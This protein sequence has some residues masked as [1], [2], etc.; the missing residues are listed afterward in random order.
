MAKADE[1]REKLDGLR[2]GPMG[3]YD[4]FFADLNE[5]LSDEQRAT[6]AKFRE[7][8]QRRG[9][10]QE[11]GVRQMMQAVRR[12]DL[13]PE[14]REKVNELMREANAPRDREER[15]SPEA[16]REFRQ[17]LFEILTP[18]QRQEF[19]RALRSDRPQQ[20]RGGQSPEERPR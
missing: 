11:A 18:E 1:L 9:G 2:R 6:V 7:Q 13:T 4:T 10:R 5:I 16:R 17:R 15:D 3:A 12:L 14:Q 19:E 8:S 20:R